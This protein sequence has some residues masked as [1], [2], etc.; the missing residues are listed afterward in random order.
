MVVLSREEEKTNNLMKL[1][2]EMFYSDYGEK[3]CELCA[4][5]GILGLSNCPE[6]NHEVGA[7]IKGEE[8]DN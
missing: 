2:R 3:F 7:A 8:D 6:C 5:S 4:G 1:A